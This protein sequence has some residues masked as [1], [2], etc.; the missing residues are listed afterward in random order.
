MALKGNR[1]GA[2]GRKKRKRIRSVFFLKNMKFVFFF[3][4]KDDNTS[5]Y[6]IK[7]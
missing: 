4:Q 6:I 2:G 1:K 7:T 3:N 5:I